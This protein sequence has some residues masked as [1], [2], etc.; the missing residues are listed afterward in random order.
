VDG[1]RYGLALF[2]VC[3]LPPLLLYWPLIH[4]FIGFWRRRGPRVTYS[5]ALSGVVLGAL[6]LYRARDALLAADYGTRWPLVAGGVVC[7]AVLGWMRGKIQSEFGVGLLVGL[8]E[9]SPQ[10]HAT[11]LVR[12]GIYARVRHPR[13]VQFWLGLLG[14]ALITNY[15]TVYV[16]WLLWLAAIGWIVV[17]EEREL[18]ER[19]GEEYREYSRQVPR[20]LPRLGARRA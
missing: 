7:I 10:R 11:P 17:L 5:V 19:F 12:T 2:L 8:P 1:F 14:W 6:A 18:R 3:T 20:F 9:L 4:G 16:L 15:L 13:Y